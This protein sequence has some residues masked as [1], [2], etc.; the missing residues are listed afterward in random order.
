MK[1]YL[2]S[3]CMQSAKWTKV[4]YITLYVAIGFM[5]LIALSSMAMF[6]KYGS[7]FTTTIERTMEDKMGGLMGSFSGILLGLVLVILI[8]AIIIYLLMAKF[9]KIFSKGNKMY[10]ITQEENYLADGYRGIGNYFLLQNIL[11]VIGFIATLIVF[12]SSISLLS[13]F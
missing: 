6:S 11:S 2:D 8:V 5:V 10:S 3:I 9:L 12:I 1:N 7:L 4:L 13:S